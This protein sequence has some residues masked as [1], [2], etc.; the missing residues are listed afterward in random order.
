M[1]FQ[2]DSEKAAQNYEKHGISFEDA[3]GIFARPHFTQRSDR[4][5]ERRW[6]AV[7]RL[8]GRLI[9]VVYTRR[10]GDIRV[11]SARRSRSDERRQYSKN[12]A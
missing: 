10:A 12:V 2:W 9:T 3:V 6:I 5:G 1:G 7:G 8:E 11:I 4:K